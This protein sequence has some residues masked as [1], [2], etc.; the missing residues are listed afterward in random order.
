MKTLRHNNYFRVSVACELRGLFERY[1]NS[2]G[3]QK[4]TV[5]LQ[6]FWCLPI[7]VTLCIRWFTV[8]VQYVLTCGT[9]TK[10]KK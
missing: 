6:R 1:Y 9:R 3:G 4:D 5:L 10:I 2:R 8:R 7:P